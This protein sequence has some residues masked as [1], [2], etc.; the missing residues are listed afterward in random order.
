MNTRVYSSSM[1]DSKVIVLPG[2]AVPLAVGN[3]IKLGPGTYCGGG[4]EEGSSVFVKPGILRRKDRDGSSS[5]WVNTQHKRVICVLF[6]QA[7][8]TI[9]TLCI[10]VK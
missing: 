4:R 6:I 10:I 2:D 1:V 8:D 5:F 7:M 9:M 3:D